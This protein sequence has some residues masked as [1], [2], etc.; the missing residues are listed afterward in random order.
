[1]P[2][3]KIKGMIDLSQENDELPPADLVDFW[4][5]EGH[6]WIRHHVVPRHEFFHPDDPGQSPPIPS[7]QLLPWRRGPS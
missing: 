6:F 5:Q 1:M 4:R 3:S 2:R 7:S